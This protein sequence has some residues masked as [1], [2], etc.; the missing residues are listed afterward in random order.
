MTQNQFLDEAILVAYA[1]GELDAETARQVERAVEENPEAKALLADLIASAGYVRTAFTAYSN[2]PVPEHVLDHVRRIPEV[3]A[4]ERSDPG[5]TRS[6]G[7]QTVM[8]LA[9]SVAFLAIGFGGGLAVSDRVTGEP[10]A[11]A[12]LVQ[13]VQFV[14][15]ERAFNDALENKLSGNSIA[16]R[17]SDGG[18]AMTVTPVKTYQSST[19]GFCREY[20]IERD[21]EG[22]HETERG[23]ACRQSD[24]RWVPRYVIIESGP[25]PV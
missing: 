19:S 13:A 14:E 21:F 23:V 10:V 15:G 16:W 8:A 11:S 18:Y 1:D 3:N 9:A 7:M 20:R 12:D 4:R 6:K 24:G 2:E 25:G 5:W 22:R 17:T